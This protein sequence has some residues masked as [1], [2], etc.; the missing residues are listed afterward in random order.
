MA[1]SK[2]LMG[3]VG[4]LCVNQKFRNDF[5]NNPIGTVTD[6]FGTPTADE[7]VQIERLAGNRDLPTGKTRDVFINE[8]KQGFQGVFAAIICSCPSPP[9]PCPDN[10]DLY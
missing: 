2:N 10:N 4:L 9:C 6:V 3:V 1:G 5:Y 7:T 8:S